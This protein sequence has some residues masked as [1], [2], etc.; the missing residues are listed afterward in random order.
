MEDKIAQ[1]EAQ[2]EGL[3]NTLTTLISRGFITLRD[4]V[5]DLEADIIALS[6]RI[7]EPSTPRKRKQTNYKDWLIVMEFHNKGYDV[8]TIVKK[9]DIADATVRKYIKWSQEDIEKAKS[10]YVAEYEQ[11]DRAQADADS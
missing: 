1:L 10:R 6:D 7:P 5:K 3:N 9:V 4:K 8:P 2:V 11:A